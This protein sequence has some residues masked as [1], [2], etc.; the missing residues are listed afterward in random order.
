MVGLGATYTIC[1]N[2]PFELETHGIKRTIHN[3][4][5]DCGVYTSEEFA[6]DI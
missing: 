5:V 2:A 1:S 6:Y 3:Y 4:H